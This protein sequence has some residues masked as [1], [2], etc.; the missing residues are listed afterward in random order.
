TK[1]RSMQRPTNREEALQS[2]ANSQAQGGVAKHIG[3]IE[4]LPFLSEKE[5]TARLEKIMAER[6][7]KWETGL[8]DA[9]M[10]TTLVAE[11]LCRKGPGYQ[12]LGKKIINT[13]FLPSMAR[14]QALLILA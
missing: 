8:F 4:L 10:A 3:E 11:L 5:L 9:S 6:R 14:Y 12:D 7:T 1:S 2:V 13:S